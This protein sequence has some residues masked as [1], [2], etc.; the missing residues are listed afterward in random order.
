MDLLRTAVV[1]ITTLAATC[2]ALKSSPDERDL[3]PQRKLRSRLR[4]E[5]KR[6]TL[7][8]VDVLARAKR[9]V[10]DAALL[11]ACRGA[12]EEQM[13]N[14]LAHEHLL[15]RIMLNEP[16]SLDGVAAARQDLWRLANMTVYLGMGMATLR[17]SSASGDT[18]FANSLAARLRRRLRKALTAYARSTLRTKVSEVR[19]MAT[20]RRSALAEIGPRGAAEAERLADIEAGAHPADSVIGR[21]VTKPLLDLALDW[22]YQDSGPT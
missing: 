20:A 22:Q 1:D 21:G 15:N 4:R 16:G 2:H 5:I 14:A 10:V 17:K 11:A 3:T 13:P 8:Y 12:A 19:P 9:G 6:G 7:A 18:K